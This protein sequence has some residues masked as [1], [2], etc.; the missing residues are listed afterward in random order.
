MAEVKHSAADADE[1]AR[2]RDEARRKRMAKNRPAPLQTGSPVEKAPEPPAAPPVSPINI[3][4]DDVS[5]ALLKR[6]MG[7]HVKQLHMS[8]NDFTNTLKFPDDRLAMKRTRMNLP[9]GTQFQIET[10][11]PPRYNRPYIETNKVGF[12]LNIAPATTD[13]LSPVAQKQRG[14]AMKFKRGFHNGDSAQFSFD[15]GSSL[16]SLSTSR[17]KPSLLLRPIHVAPDEAVAGS[18]VD[19]L[20]KRGRSETDRKNYKAAIGKFSSALFQDPASIVALFGRGVAYALRKE[21]SKANADF[22]TCLEE[23]EARYSAATFYNRGVTR[24]NLGNI[25]GAIDDFSAAVR[26]QSKEIDFYFNRALCYRSRND[27]TEALADYE[28]MKKIQIE[29]ERLAEEALNKSEAQSGNQEK[30]DD[31]SGVING[32]IQRNVTCYMHRTKSTSQLQAE[33]EGKKKR[34]IVNLERALRRAPHERSPPEIDY[35]LSVS[36]RLKC[37]SSCSNDELRLLWRHVVYKKYE[38]RE[39]LFEKG[40]PSDSFMIVFQGAVSVRIPRADI[41]DASRVSIEQCIGDE[42]IV[43]TMTEGD[44]LGESV[45]DEGAVRSAACIALEQLEV[46]YLDRDGYLK[47]FHQFLIKQKHFKETLLKE[48][49]LFRDWPHEKLVPL[50]FISREQVYESDE[51]V[52][53]QGVSP[54]ALYFV[55]SGSLKKVREVTDAAGAKHRVQVGKAMPGDIFGEEVLLVGKSGVDV[56]G[57]YVSII[58]EYRARVLRIDRMQLP[59]DQIGEKERA[60]LKEMVSDYTNDS[61]LLQYEV[62]ATTWEQERKALF[63]DI[64]KASEEKAKAKTEKSSKFKLEMETSPH[65]MSRHIRAMN[66]AFQTPRK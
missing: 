55:L 21:W 11:K 15:A 30:N 29:A 41:K 37:L 50:A 7:N 44:Y 4:V 23:E 38:A 3:D 57:S 19:N 16:T 42:V 54:D 17:S 58:A 59:Y 14:P 47:T 56:G 52:I 28:I 33:K 35:L 40:D 13:Y 12:K 32:A 1:K 39:R 61:Y 63:A 34:V 27:W 18:Y 36:R 2:R 49:P 26:L 60:T 24:A 5:R 9:I 51:V 43:N 64:F 10:V 6:A 22:T 31:G 45:A 62:D 53:H 20:I 8:G 25:Q 48:V 66:G 65:Q 46:L